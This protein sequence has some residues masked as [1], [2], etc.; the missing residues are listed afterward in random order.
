MFVGA[1]AWGVLAWQIGMSPS[2]S[3]TRASGPSGITATR[4]TWHQAANQDAANRITEP[5]TGTFNLPLPNL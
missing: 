3:A 4:T 2:G 1:G 5:I